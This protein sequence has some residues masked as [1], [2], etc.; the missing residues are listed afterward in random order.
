MLETSLMLYL[1]PDLVQMGKAEYVEDAI[2]PPYEVLPEDRSRISKSG[3]LSNP[4]NGSAE[5][6]KI[7]NDD[8]VG[9]ALASIRTE[10][11]Q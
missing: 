1:R 10:F 9:T 3:S 4:L 2:F 11:A 5:I 7:V 8:M 6:G